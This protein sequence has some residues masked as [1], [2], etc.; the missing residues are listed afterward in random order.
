IAI[1][2]DGTPL[3]E[4]TV[5]ICREA[6]AVLLGAVGGPKWDQN[7]G[8]LRPETGLLGIRKAL[9]LFANIRP[10]NM[11]P[12]LVEASSLKP[13]AVAGVDLIVVRELTG[14][15]YFGEKQ[16]YTGEDGK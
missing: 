13:E 2:T 11:H 5:N 12:T 16:R 3:P 8:H 9:G 10:A 1:D 6:D 14:G 4:E 15:I 7:P